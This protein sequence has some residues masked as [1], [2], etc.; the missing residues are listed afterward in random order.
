MSAGGTESV[1]R[2]TTNKLHI[3]HNKN[4]LFTHYGLYRYDTGVLS[5]HT[6]YIQYT[7]MLTYNIY[8]SISHFH[9][10]RYRV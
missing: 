6:V 4:S 1:L 3:Y 10:L 9:I 5:L 8:S 2:E 7:G